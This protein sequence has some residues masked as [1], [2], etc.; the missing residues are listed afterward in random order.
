MKRSGFA[1]TEELKKKLATGYRA[2]DKSEQHA[3]APYA[4]Y[5]QASGMLYSSVEDIAEILKLQFRQGPAGG[6]Q[7]LGSS[8]LKEMMAPLFVANDESTVPERFWHQGLGLGWRILAEEGL[9]FNL[10]RG[11]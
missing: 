4:A 11:G 6:K 3:L 7:I 10:Q 2:A 8:A 9:Q 5:G 1:V